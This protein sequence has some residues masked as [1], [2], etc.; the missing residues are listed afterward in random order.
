VGAVVVGD[1]QSRDDDFVAAQSADGT[2]EP[3]DGG[4]GSTGG[5][6]SGHDE[7]VSWMDGL[8]VSILAAPA[9]RAHRPE[10]EQ[11]VVV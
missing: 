6:G 10:S 4:L 8:A 1:G 9:A 3:A 11:C 2:L 7:V 5:G